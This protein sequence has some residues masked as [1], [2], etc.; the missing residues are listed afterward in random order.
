LGVALR[1][2]L[3]L[4][5]LTL[6][7]ARAGLLRTVHIPN[8][9]LLFAISWATSCALRTIDDRCGLACSPAFSAYHGVKVRRPQFRGWRLPAIE[10]AG[11]CFACGK[12]S[13]LTS[14]E[15]LSG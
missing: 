12:D 9:V 4:A 2:G 5:P 13:T 10:E 15:L 14:R 11:C 7:P 1:A 3:L 6:G 8:A